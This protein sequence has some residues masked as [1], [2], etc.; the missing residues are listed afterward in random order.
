MSPEIA[1]PCRTCKVLPPDC[2]GSVCSLIAWAVSWAALPVVGALAGLSQLPTSPELC[3]Q[4]V[5]D[6]V[7][8]LRPIQAES[9]RVCGFTLSF[10]FSP[11]VQRAIF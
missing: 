1:V 11:A 2:Y 5:Q 4:A 10:A 6:F 3:T 8:P 9:R 7:Q